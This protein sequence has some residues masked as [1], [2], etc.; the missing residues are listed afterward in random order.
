MLRTTT[1]SGGGVIPNA[2]SSVSAAQVEWTP[3]QTPHARLLMK[4]ASRGSRP[5]RITS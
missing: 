3:P 1:P 4:I 5:F 2:I